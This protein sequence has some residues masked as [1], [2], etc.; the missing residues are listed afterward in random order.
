MHLASGVG[1]VGVLLE[2]SSFGDGAGHREGEMGMEG[3]RLSPPA[4][5]ENASAGG[6]GIPGGIASC[7]SLSLRAGASAS[8]VGAGSQPLQK[9]YGAC[10]QCWFYALVCSHGQAE[11]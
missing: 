5:E 11:C 7:S 8:A 3:Q 6:A 9:Q 4:G 1:R 2:M 10:M